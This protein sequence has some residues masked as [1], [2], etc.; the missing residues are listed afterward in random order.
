MQTMGAYEAKTHFSVLLEQVVQGEE[1]LITRH[2][3]P[4]AKLVSVKPHGPK[5]V[6][7]AI[8]RLKVFSQNHTLGGMDWKSLRDEGRR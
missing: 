8:Q 6:Q 2:G 7:Q 3:H 4:V 1:F 5:Q